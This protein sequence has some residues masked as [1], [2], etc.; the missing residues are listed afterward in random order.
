LVRGHFPYGRSRRSRQAGRSLQDR[1]GEIIA[2]TESEATYQ[3]L[4]RS[5]ERRGLKGVEPVTSGDH[6]RLK[7]AARLD[8]SKSYGIFWFNR[9]RTTRK[10][11]LVAGANGREYKW[12]YTVRDNPRE[13]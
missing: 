8:D 2:Y 13:P 12:R 4:F 6:G 3:E 9:R 10:R 5:L 1:D 7:A 11:V